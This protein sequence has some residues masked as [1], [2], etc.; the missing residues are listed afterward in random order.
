MA[1]DCKSA[2]VESFKSSDKK[3]L[4]ADAKI[5]IA[6]IKKQPQKR[7]DLCK[8]AGMHPA[9][10]SRVRRLL[11]NRGIVRKTAT[12]YVLWYYVEPKNLWSKLLQEFEKLG[13]SLTRIAIQKAT[14]TGRDPETGWMQF[15]YDT[16]SSIEGIMILK[17]AIELIALVRSREIFL[18]DEYVGAVLTCDMIELKDR[19]SWADKVYEVWDVEERLNNDNSLAYRVGKFKLVF[20]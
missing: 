20:V 11:E 9:S 14:Y 19:V 2:A 13:C 17:D 10:F 15:N 6:L 8:S 7:L 5:I 4:S 12:G 3:R 16:K 18:H 1:K